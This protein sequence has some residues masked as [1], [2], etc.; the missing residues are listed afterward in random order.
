MQ[1]GSKLI[2]REWRI[3]EDEVVV[4]RGDNGGGVEYVVRACMRGGGDGLGSP[5]ENVLDPSQV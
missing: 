4:V 1:R 5:R 3:E 2:G